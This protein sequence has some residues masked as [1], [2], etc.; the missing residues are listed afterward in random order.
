[1]TLKNR[2]RYHQDQRKP[3]YYA[4]NR[5]VSGLPTSET[6]LQLF[7]FQKTCTSAILGQPF[8]LQFWYRH[9]SH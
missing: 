7:S 9:R 3:Q 5:V 6:R 4:N 2:R 1:M 8:L